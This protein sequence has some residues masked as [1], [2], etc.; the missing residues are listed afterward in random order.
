MSFVEDTSVFI[1]G[2]QLDDITNKMNLELKTTF[3]LVKC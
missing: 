2:D 1:H 3:S